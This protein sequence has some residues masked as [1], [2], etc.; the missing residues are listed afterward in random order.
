[1]ALEMGSWV[2]EI[3]DDTLFE[4]VEGK[5]AGVIPNSSTKKINFSIEIL[6]VEE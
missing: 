3:R 4:C 5:E 1:M 2:D 6:S